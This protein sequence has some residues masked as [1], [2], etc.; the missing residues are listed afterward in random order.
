MTH[1]H[2]RLRKGRTSQPGGI[3]LI[4]FCTHSRKLLFRNRQF[5]VDAVSALLEQRHWTDAQLLTWVLM[6]DHWHGLI[7]LHGNIALAHVIGRLKGASAH[8]I[9]RR[10]PSASPIWQDAF[11]D[12]ALRAEEDLLAT[13]AYIVHNPVRAGLVATPADYPY[14][15]SQWRDEFIAAS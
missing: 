12:H 4:T 1:G 10:H 14:W 11:H 8:T 5:A 15:G 6:P 7:Q 2:H 9:G 3:Y 13:A